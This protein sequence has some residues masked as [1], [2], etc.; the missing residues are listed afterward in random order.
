M[1]QQQEQ[2]KSFI[3]IVFKD[4]GSVEFNAMMDGIVPMQLLA[5]AEY[6]HFLGES[7]LVQEKVKEAQRAQQNKIVV[8]GIEV[9]K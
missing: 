3:Q 2:P 5:L 4:I 1:D 8:P 7:G 9:S 6:L